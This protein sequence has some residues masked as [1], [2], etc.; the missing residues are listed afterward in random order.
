MSR[1]ILHGAVD[2]VDML[3]CVE[4]TGATVSPR[5]WWS[6]QVAAMR[7][8][9]SSRLP[10]RDAVVGLVGVEGTRIA[11]SQQQRCSSSPAVG[12]T[13]QTLEVRRPDR[14]RRELG[15]QAA[16]ADG[17]Q[18]AVI[19]DEDETPAI[20]LGQGESSWYSDGVDS[21]P[22]SSTT[23][24]EYR[25]GMWYLGRWWP[26]WTL[27]FVEELGDGVRAHPG[28]TFEHSGRFSPSGA[29]SPNTGRRC[30]CRSSTPAAS[31]RVLPAPAGPTTSTRG[32]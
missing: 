6:I 31:M 21:I 2:G 7:S 16:A 26:V 10:G 29:S 15:E 22:A 11:G 1:G 27:P 23:R 19:S 8:R 14:W 9:W 18:L 5:C 3:R 13:V 30:H 12:E 17:L 32:S 4:A 24:V 20:R 28:V 25:L